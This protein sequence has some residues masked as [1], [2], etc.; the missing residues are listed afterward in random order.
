[1]RDR[2]SMVYWWPRV[3]HLSVPMPETEIIDVGHEHLQGLL[4]GRRLPLEIEVQILGAADR[5]GYP[6]FLRTDQ[7]SAKH[8]WERACWVPSRDVLLEHLYAVVEYNELV[9]MLGLPYSAVVLRKFIPLDHRFQAFHGNLPISRERRY[10]VLDGR[11]LCHHPYWP[12]EA[13]AEAEEGSSA[14]DELAWLED[15]VG[16]ESIARARTGRSRLPDNWRELLRELNVEPEEE[17][18]LLSR[19]AEEIGAALGGYWSV[20]FARGADGTW[21]F[22]DAAAG[23]ESWHPPCPYAS[24]AGLF[25]VGGDA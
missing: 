25:P 4:D 9:D 7:A 3:M 14:W 23:E 2:S 21:Y 13:I 24:F 8:D 1:M 20:D 18:R 16:Q 19:Y 15:V 10:F 22:I 17:V 11:V 12:E 5:L 6:V